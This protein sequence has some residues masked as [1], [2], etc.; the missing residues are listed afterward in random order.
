M[1]RPSSSS[2]TPGLLS[3]YLQSITDQYSDVALECEGHKFSCH[4]VILAAQSKFF[5]SLFSDIFGGGDECKH[6]VFA[7]P[8]V[9]MIGLEK[10]IR[11]I[12]SR[13]MHLTMSTVWMV[14]GTEE[15][16]GMESS[17][18]VRWLHDDRLVSRKVE[19]VWSLAM[20]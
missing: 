16:L 1:T 13:P 15:F 18:L 14:G 5:S 17:L 9:S 3:S 7:L 11:F 6:P 20:T 10:V 8:G 4:R 19:E 12:Y 2:T